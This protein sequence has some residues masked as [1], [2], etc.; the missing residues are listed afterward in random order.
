MLVWRGCVVRPHVS[1]SLQAGN[2]INVGNRERNPRDYN[3]KGNNMNRTKLIV[4]AI[5]IIGLG[6]LIYRSSDEAYQLKENTQE[7]IKIGRKYAYFL[8]L[9]EKEGLSNIS[10]EPARSKIASADFQQMAMSEIFDH[11]DKNKIPFSLQIPLLAEKEDLRLIAFEKLDSFVVMTF[12]LKGDGDQITEISNKG[13]M[14]YSVAIR[15]YRP[16]DDRFLSKLKRKIANLPLLRDFIGHLGTTGRWVVF[17]YNYTYSRNDYFKWLL[18]ERKSDI[19]FKKQLESKEFIEK[20]YKELL[21]S[22]NK[23]LDFLYEWGSLTVKE[24]IK[25]IEQLYGEQKKT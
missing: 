5:I 4:I 17:D 9:S 15:Y 10:I 20:L 12:A 13:K 21:E 14:L 16:V 2:K 25:R 11:L 23:H 8:F 22:A 19:E 18:N 24:Q 6:L 7:A 1:R 3:I